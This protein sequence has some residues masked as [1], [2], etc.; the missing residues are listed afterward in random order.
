MIS[1]RLA[2][3]LILVLAAV[4]DGRITPEEGAEILAAVID[5]VEGEIGHAAQGIADDLVAF[6]EHLLHPDPHELRNRAT[7]AALDGRP[8]RAARLV[9]RAV[10]IEGRRG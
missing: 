9:A 8:E 7:A 6:V 5:V 10:R 4:R 3:P 2:R 1:T